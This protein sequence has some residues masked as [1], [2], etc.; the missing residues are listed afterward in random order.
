M[1]LG[2][3]RQMK[4]M[5]GLLLLYAG[6]GSAVGGFLGVVSAY[7]AP[8]LYASRAVME[9]GVSN[10][11]PALREESAEWV[12]EHLD[13]A[14]LW[15]TEESA[16]VERVMASYRA[17]PGER[18][19]HYV[20]EVRASSGWDA[21][22]I[23]EALVEAEVDSAPV[24]WVRKSRQL[25]RARETIEGE[26]SSIREAL[27]DRPVPGPTASVSE[28]EAYVARPGE[29][30]RS[31]AEW[32]VERQRVEREFAELEGELAKYE[33]ASPAPARAV[34]EAP[35]EERVPVSPDLDRRRDAGRVAGALLGGL[36]WGW[37]APR[38]E[39]RPCEP[40]EMPAAS[41]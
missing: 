30:R 12:V 17:L 40:E 24:P 6:V 38:R 11:L 20:I 1:E 32:E 29:L 10:G 22:R 16:A 28:L 26:I 34:M 25:A 35:V 39:G 8:K 21:F 37:K 4:R 19:E 33:A 36:L 31:L 9:A 3:L 5:L 2:T 41:Y 23:A 27:S 18:P 13:L 14:T 7:W 15:D